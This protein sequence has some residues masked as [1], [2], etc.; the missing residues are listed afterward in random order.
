MAVS[1]FSMQKKRGER[2]ANKKI[3][4][5]LAADG[6]REFTQA[7]SNAKKESALL[8]A[9]LKNLNT[10]YKGN[11][12]SLE[13]LSKK[14]E[15]LGKQTESYQKKV[16]SAKEGL[17]HAQTVSQKAA[18]RYDELKEALEKAQKAQE[19][20]EKTGQSGTEEYQKQA[21]EVEDLQKALDKQGLECQKCEG[22]ISDWNKKLVD[23][24]TDVKKNS[25]AL[26]QNAEYL[27]EAEN[28]TD[29]CAKSIDGFGKATSITI[30]TTKEFTQ[31]LKEGLAETLASKG[32]DVAADAIAKTGEAVKETM[33]D[34]SSASTKL[35][36]STGASSTAMTKY[37][38]VMKQIKGNNYGESY[39]DVAE[40]MGVVIQTM[41][42]LNDTDLQNITESAM[43]LS[44]AFGYDYQEQLRAVDM[45]MK[46]FGVTSEE[47][48]NLI[49][50]GTQ[51]GLNKNGDLLD[52]INE[53]SVHYAQMGVTAEGFFNSL[54]NGTEAGT[55]SVDKLGDAYKEFGIRVKDTNTTTEEGYGLLG[56]NADK[57]RD[58]FAEGGESAAKATDIVLD[59]LMNMDDKVKQNQ[60]GVDLFGTMWED[61]GVEGVRALTNLDGSISKTKA[62]MEDLKKVQ[63]SDL[64]S[65]VSGLGAA[66]QEHITT[67]IADKALPAI[68]G[69]FEGATEI[70]NG[71]GEALTPQ[72]TEIQTFVDE[73]EAANEEIGELIDSAK[74]SV[75]TAKIDVSNLEA[76]KTTLLSVNEI[77][78]KDEYQKYQVKAA[79]EALSQSIPE[80]KAAYDEETGSI[81]LTN[82]EIERLIENQEQLLLQ[83]ALMETQETA[84]KAVT[85]ATLNKAKADA[86]VNA[87][88]K[89]GGEELQRYMDLSE[90]GNWRLAENLA[91]ANPELR[92]MAS[93][94]REAWAEQTEANKKLDEANG[95]YEEEKEAIE[96][97]KKQYGLS[98]ETIE[99]NSSA[100]DA[101]SEKQEQLSLKQKETAKG[102]SE[103][104]EAIKGA[105]DALEEN[106]GAADAAAEA[107]KNAAKSVSDAYHGYVDEIKSDLQDKISL[108]DK[109]D[110]S[111][112]GEDQTVEKITEN[113]NSQIE[114]YQEYE[115]NLAEVR[116][117]VG[118]EIAPEFMQ[119]LESMG[120]EGSNTLKHIL[121]TFEDGEP[122]KVKEMSDK[123][124][125][126]MD[127]SEEI[128]EVQAAN[129]LAYEISIKEFGSTDI[130]FTELSDAI[131]KASQNA[132]EGWNGLTEATKTA[133]EEA[134]QT[135][136]DMGVKIPDG[137]A[138]GIAS[139]DVSAEDALA[140]LTGTIQGTM[141]GL[142]D[143]A[144]EM[145]ISIPPEIAEGI[146]A[147]GQ[148]AV[149][150]YN[151][152]ITLIASQ[153]ATLEETGT[154]T[155]NNAGDSIVSGIQEKSEEVSSAAGEVAEAGAAAMQEKANNYFEAGSLSASEYLRGIASAQGN[156]SAAGSALALAVKNAISAQTGFYG[157]GVNMAAGVASGIN[158]GA[159]RAIAAARNMA[160]SA[161]A[162]AKAELDIHS[163]S[164]KFR[165]QVGAQISTG[166]A[167]GI[168]DKASLAG[169]AAK[170]MSN[171][172]YT[173]AVSWLSAYKKKQQVSLQDE[174]WYWQQVLE[175]TK[176]GTTAYNNALKKIQNVTISELTASG[177]SSAA[178]TKI[179]NNFGVSKTTKSGK[180]KK[181]K[182]SETYYSEVYSAAEKYLSNQQVLNDWS[183]Q[184]ELAYWKAVK[185]QLKK[186]T[187]AWYDAQKQINN[188][189]ADIADAEAKAAEEK[190]KTHAD[191]QNDILDKYKVYYKISAKAEADYW[192]IARKQFKTGTDERI[193]ADQKYYEAL[194]EW[195][196]ERRE[197]DEEYAENSQEINDELIESVQELQDAYH[198]AV[199]SRKQDILSSMSL[200]ESWDASGYDADTLLYNLQTQVAGLALWEQQLEELGTK[201]L[202]EGLMEELRQMGPDAAANIYSLN[203]MTAEQLAEYN[204]LWEQRESLAESQAVKDN[205]SLLKETNE[206]ISELRKDAQSELDLLNA[207]YKAA[208][209]ELNTGISSDLKNLVN[210]AGSIGE[211]AVSG[212]ISSIGKAATSVETYN[213]TT[214]VVNSISDQLGTLTDAGKTIGA[215]AL[216]SILNQLTNQEKINTAAKSAAESIKT[217]MAEELIYRQDAMNELNE[218]GNGGVT[219]L[220]NLTKEYGS[221]QTIVNV[222][223]S[224]VLATMQQITSNLIA[225]IDL[226]QNSQLVM[227]TGVVAAELQPLIS[228]ESA[229]ITVRRN[230]GLY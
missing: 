168:R 15:I 125:E 23:A 33:Y 213:S 224:G 63:Y 198:D 172:V 6:E 187:Q 110:T 32:L 39:N 143:V 167:F 109:F 192:N 190:I 136:R 94:L 153:T 51:Q 65:A 100:V 126:A 152:L 219:M 114:A 127:V 11:A 62:S 36:A 76:Y 112:G 133:L 138:E 186:G 71:V 102:A 203:Q 113:L 169:K 115:K 209:S 50:Q 69:L 40:A 57:M 162:A 20:L 101:N 206:E 180:K 154:E 155:G 55:F 211:E 200:F 43:T 10:E 178:A 77:E 60:A 37:N 61:L 196:D 107:Q 132:G 86:A 73:I 82:G 212:L 30:N 25:Q 166:M 93:N 173:N 159:S 130:E 144:K 4:I 35:Q 207:E 96:E 56:L 139:G 38:A 78:Q 46:Q 145:G 175:H 121:Q 229:A 14:Q 54:A 210:K 120:L 119:Y 70:I 225:L 59:A 161:L 189:Q 21:K 185:G 80:L 128:S 214:K 135:A 48:F 205:E 2:M 222:D 124:V 146:A 31:S 13:Y 16:E 47:A 97:V 223:N 158:D 150:A 193:E 52:T 226:I 12:N 177:I 201:G 230:R 49:V 104:T 160:A 195:Y 99:E 26:E 176:K 163:P 103:E 3:G 89:E 184:Q 151:A 149:D 147:G 17:E 181:T 215:D 66:L 83:N 148:E 27:K 87:I 165:N 72:K 117:H 131:E 106:A 22:K 67:P 134:E 171:K 227:D 18:K 194:Q 105:T 221:Q 183:L 197:L 118:K 157:A 199:A 19:E 85:D 28:A 24:E 140:Q 156:A 122:E 7:L 44:D 79:V 64:E 164:K 95:L 92:D 111:S 90:S 116:D 208:L 204:K 188:L 137:L 34:I 53:Y 91:K 58:A 41:G 108:F 170:R 88:L 142:T 29:D 84:I 216:E 1:L 81:N 8:N 74:T 217:A 75:E 179:T 123:W 5:I 182:D 218:I 141:D 9:E 202:T 220:N 174:K 68:T 42:E 228:Q 129:K 191:V 45:L 98:T